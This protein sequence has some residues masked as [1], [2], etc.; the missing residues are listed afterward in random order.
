M[1]SLCRSVRAHLFLTWS[2]HLP[3]SEPDMERSAEK[4]RGAVESKPPYNND[5]DSPGEC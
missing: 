4:L 3:L 2:E 1:N 5:V